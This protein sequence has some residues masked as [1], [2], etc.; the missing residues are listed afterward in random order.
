RRAEDAP[1]L[2]VGAAGRAL[3]A[4]TLGWL[5]RPYEEVGMVTKRED[6]GWAVGGGIVA[7]AVGGAVDLIALLISSTVK[8][9]DVWLVM[10]GA[11]APFIGHRAMQPGFDP[12]AILA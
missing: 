2:E 8:H 4:P 1:S 11:A 9:M 5:H 12:F 7:G 6:V 10:K 3:R